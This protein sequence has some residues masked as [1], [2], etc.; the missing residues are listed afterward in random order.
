MPQDLGE[1]KR[2]TGQAGETALLR[3]STKWYR[4]PQKNAGDVVYLVM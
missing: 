2:E 3:I 1:V 4:C